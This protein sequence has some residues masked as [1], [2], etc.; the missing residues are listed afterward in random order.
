M[1]VLR[2]LHDGKGNEE[3]IIRANIVK[4]E[5]MELLLSWLSEVEERALKK[6]HLDFTWR[7]MVFV[8]D[9]RWV[10]FYRRFLEEHRVRGYFEYEFYAFITGEGSEKVQVLSFRYIRS[11]ENVVWLVYEMIRTKP[12]SIL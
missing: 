7:D 6:G 11:L 2:V 9:Y 8:V 1:E 10:G 4:S 12:D 3:F 5:E